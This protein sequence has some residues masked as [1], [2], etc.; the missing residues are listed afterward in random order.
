VRGS[1]DC[2]A[3]KDAV[4]GGALKAYLDKIAKKFGTGSTP[5][6]R[7]RPEESK[8]VCKF[9]KEG[10]CK[11]AERCNFAHE[12]QGGSKRPRVA[13]GKGKSKGKGKDKRKG[14]GR[15]KGNRARQGTT[16]VV[17]KKVSFDEDAGSA[18]IVGESL[19]MMQ[20][21]IKTI[22]EKQKMNYTIS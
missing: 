19:H 6:K 12:G 15:G 5:T 13:N 3:G 10:Y 18:M 16:M 7:G 4:W 2:R 21:R 20:R 11:Y 17:E 1:P 9:F 22:I 8:P 14:K